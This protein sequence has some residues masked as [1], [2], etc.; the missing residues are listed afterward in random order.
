MQDQKAVVLTRENAVDQDR[1]S[2]RLANVITVARRKANNVARPHKDL[3]QR[4]QD[5]FDNVR[6]LRRHDR[7]TAAWNGVKLLAQ[8]EVDR[9]NAISGELAVRIANRRR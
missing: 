5:E 2:L 3:H 1:R 7:R 8:I 9:L 6:N 4:R